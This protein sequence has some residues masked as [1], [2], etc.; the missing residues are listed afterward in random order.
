MEEI[1]NAAKFA[2]NQYSITGI[3]CQHNASVEK[4]EIY[5]TSDKTKKLQSQ[6]LF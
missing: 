3:F 6:C 5:L 1:I 2:R 4:L